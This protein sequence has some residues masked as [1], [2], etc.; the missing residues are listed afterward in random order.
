MNALGVKLYHLRL[1]K[2]LSELNV[3]IYYYNTRLHELTMQ[4]FRGAMQHTWCRDCPYVFVMEDGEAKER[5]S[6]ESSMEQIEQN[7]FHALY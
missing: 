6:H 7:F 1:T 3:P 2:L 4:T 5:I